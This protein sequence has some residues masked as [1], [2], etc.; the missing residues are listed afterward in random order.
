MHTRIGLAMAALIGAP[1]CGAAD[2]PNAAGE[3]GGAEEAG[4]PPHH[5]ELSLDPEGPAIP[6]IVAAGRYELAAAC[7][8]RPGAAVR[9][10]DPLEPGAFADVPCASMLGGDPTQE[11]SAVPVSEGAEPIGEAQQ[12]L[13]PLS[14]GCAAFVLGS[15]LIATRGICPRARDPRA[16]KHCN[17]WSDAGFGTLTLMCAFF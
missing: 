3:E 8:D 11:Q 13:S 4:L 15:T 1:A 2:E 17:L 14:L 5:F 12:R 7:A 16:E 10:F 9:I 6:Q